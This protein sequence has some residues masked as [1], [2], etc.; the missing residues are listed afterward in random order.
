MSLDPERLALDAAQSILSSSH[1]RFLAPPP[2]LAGH[3]HSAVAGLL[4]Q[5]A[6]SYELQLAHIHHEL[7]AL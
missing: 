1:A 5:P 2:N 6:H 7:L 3:D 4:N